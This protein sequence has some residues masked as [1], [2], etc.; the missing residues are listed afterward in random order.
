MKV[1]IWPLKE[2]RFKEFEFAEEL[3]EFYRNDKEMVAEGNLSSNGGVR[4]HRYFSGKYWFLFHKEAPHLTICRQN[5]RAPDGLDEHTGAYHIWA[6]RKKGVG[7]GHILAKVHPEHYIPDTG[8]GLTATDDV[9][10]DRER[11]F[12]NSPIFE[13]GYM[14]PLEP[15]LEKPSPG[16]VIRV[17]VGGVWYKTLID[18]SGTQRFVPNSLYKHLSGGGG[19][20]VSQLTKDYIDG[21]FAR[22]EFLEFLMGLGI[23][24]QELAEMP[25]FSN[26]EFVNPMYL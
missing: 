25:V 16:D 1:E 11:A 5:L 26:L 3:L 20:N 19:F 22:R 15:L 9:L 8:Y 18:K 10:C 13:K 24:Y 23:Y 6:G 7:Y 17:Q 2:N 4:T 14:K 21:K 12:V